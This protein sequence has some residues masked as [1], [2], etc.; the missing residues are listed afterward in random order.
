M[1][2]E[3]LKKLNLDL[4]NLITK[5]LKEKNISYEWS[6]NISIEEGNVCNF[7]DISNPNRIDLTKLPFI[8]IDDENSKDFDDAIYC[9]KEKNGNW[10][11]YV[12]IADVSFFIRPNSQIDKEAEKRGRSIYFADLVIPMLPE[13]I[14]NNICSLQPNKVRHCLTCEMQITQDGTIKKFEFYPSVIKSSERFT[15]TRINQFLSGNITL[16]GLCNSL[17]L[18]LQAVSDSL[19]KVRTLQNNNLEIS[20]REHNYILDEKGNIIDLKIKN[21]T[22]A[23]KIV[24]ECMVAANISAAKFI[25][26]SNCDFIYRVQQLPNSEKIANVNKALQHI[27]LSIGNNKNDFSLFL[28]KIKGNPNEI[29][30]EKLLLRAMTRA[31]YS[32]EKQEH[33]LLGISEYT[34][35]TSPIRRYSDLVVHRIIKYCIKQNA[36]NNYENQLEQIKNSIKVKVCQNKQNA[37]IFSFIKS[38]L[39]FGGTKVIYDEN[40]MFKEA[41]KELKRPCFSDIGD[42]KYSKE[43]LTRI[44]SIS[45]NQ[46]TKVNEIVNEINKWFE[47]QYF[48]KYT[49]CTFTGT[50]INI[51]NF[52][53]F[54]LLDNCLLD[55]FVYIGSLGN[56]K[57]NLDSYSNTLI[58]CNSR[59]VFYVGQRL[60]LRLNSISIAQQR[61]SF[62]I[63]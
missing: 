53:L 3:S 50:V 38:K 13:N 15:Y 44:C 22:P 59:K 11:L 36:I 57:F 51:T 58:G 21:I 12:S 33:Y 39:G 20:N 24:E 46:E 31:S 27:G 62:I 32:Q 63:V 54:V 1:F 42:K 8:T 37:N 26:E 49:G 56:E 45:T 61:A 60:T 17:I 9:S 25:Y 2:N 40:L 34:H 48:S 14:S 43:E 52:G 7:N 30:L 6:S 47:M 55:A 28:K 4:R 5:T 19:H 16:S 18:N 10:K 23:H 29:A 35:F 41:T